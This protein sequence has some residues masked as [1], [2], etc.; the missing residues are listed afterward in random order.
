MARLF[1]IAHDGTVT[2]PTSKAFD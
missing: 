2:P 1:V